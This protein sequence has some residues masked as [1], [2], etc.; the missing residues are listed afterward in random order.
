MVLSFDHYKSGKGMAAAPSGTSNGPRPLE[1]EF[2]MRKPY[3]TASPPR[4]QGNKEEY[5]YLKPSKRGKCP[6]MQYHSIQI[7]YL[8]AF[9]GPHKVGGGFEGKPRVPHNFLGGSSYL[10][11][12]GLRISRSLC[13]PLRALTTQKGSEGDSASRRG[14]P[15]L[16][17]Q[18]M[19]RSSLGKTCW[20]DR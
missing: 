12:Q 6:P 3:V 1:T 13:L 9:C 16:E 19:G 15:F 2:A 8:G 7:H 5:H 14:R 17:R 20:C 18:G 10:I 4:N 11:N